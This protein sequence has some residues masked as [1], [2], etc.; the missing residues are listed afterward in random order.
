MK[1]RN[2]TDNSHEMNSYLL[3]NIN[4][5]LVPS[6]PPSLPHGRKA[7]REN[8]PETWRRRQLRP[9]TAPNDFEPNINA[10]GVIMKS[11]FIN[12]ILR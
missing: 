12:Q 5:Y 4:N 3:P 9:T 10:K 6:P 2:S 8:K 1:H 11:I 7:T